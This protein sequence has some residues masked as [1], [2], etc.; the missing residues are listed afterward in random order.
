M[1]LKFSHY[2]E[3]IKDIALQ[4]RCPTVSN[5]YIRKENILD[6]FLTISNLQRTVPDINQFPLLDNNMIFIDSEHYSQGLLLP[7]E[8]TTAIATT[9]LRTCALLMMQIGADSLFFSHL[10]RGFIGYAATGLYSQI[11]YL[12]NKLNNRDL[13]INSIVFSPALR[14]N[15]SY[16]E[17]LL[18]NA[19]N[20]FQLIPRA[21]QEA[22]ALTTSK[23]W[24]ITEV[25]FGEIKDI[26]SGSWY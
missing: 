20:D 10:Y 22:F 2:L 15:Y 3:S 23:Q 26:H 19:S 25:D 17:K 8:Q 11:E 18:A 14:T 21:Y 16:A 1:K 4:K 5:I 24:Q 6:S 7:L 9:E 13:Q 12:L